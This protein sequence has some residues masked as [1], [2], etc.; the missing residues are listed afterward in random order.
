MKSKE[1]LNAIKEEVETLSKKLSE[2]TGDELEQVCG[3]FL[4]NNG[5]ESL[6]GKQRQ[7]VIIARAIAVNPT[8][9]MKE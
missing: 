1:E 7:R 9:L 2:L 8:L 4:V 6:S 3:G 5:Q